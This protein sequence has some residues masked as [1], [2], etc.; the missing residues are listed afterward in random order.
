MWTTSAP[1]GPPAAPTSLLLLT[2]KMLARVP[3]PTAVVAFSVV[4]IQLIVRARTRHAGYA[5]VRASGRSG[6]WDVPPAAVL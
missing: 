4:V 2:P 5:P 3:P 6:P 1:S